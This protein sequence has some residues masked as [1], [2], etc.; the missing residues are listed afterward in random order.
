MSAETQTQAPT[1]ATV[2]ARAEEL[3]TEPCSVVW[4]RGHAYVLESGFGRARWA[5]VDE[6]GR[7]V[8]LTSDELRRRGW[9]DTRD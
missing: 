3:P 8:L 9:S 5:G 4:S 7:P 6:R 1:A 2:A